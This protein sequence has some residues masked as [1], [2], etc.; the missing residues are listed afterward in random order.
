MRHAHL[1]LFALVGLML[2]GAPAARATTYALDPEHSSVGFKI[3]H[4]FS[5]VKGTFNDVEGKFEYVP[6][7]P[8]Q[9]TVTATVI[10]GT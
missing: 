10:Q 1:G 3:R 6:G 9:W 7:Q 5:N 2:C 4:L 8:D